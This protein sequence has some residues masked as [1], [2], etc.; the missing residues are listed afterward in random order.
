MRGDT[1]KRRL[2]VLPTTM[3]AVWIALASLIP[4]PLLQPPP[5]A[6]QACT[7]GQ[8]G[9]GDPYFPTMGNG[10]YDV[11]HYDLDLEIDVPGS[12][13]VTATVTLEALAFVDLCSFNLD[14]EGL[15]IEEVTIDDIP[16]TFS[17]NGKELTITP[18]RAIEAGEWFAATVRYHGKPV[19]ASFSDSEPK[20]E[21]AEDARRGLGGG[22]PDEVI[23]Y[24]G[25]WFTAK[26]EIFTLGQPTGS[27]FWYPVNEHPADKATYSATYT[28][29][30]PF[31]VV[32]N[33]SPIDQIDDESTTTYVWESRDSIASYLVTFHAGRLE[34]EELKGPNGLPIRLSFAPSVPEDQRAVFRKLPDMIAYAETVFGPYP[35]ES[36]GATVT[37]TKQNAA[38]ETQTLP[39]YGSKGDSRDTP[40]TA[41]QIHTVEF[42]IFHEMAHQWFGNSVS[43][44]H[45]QD[46]WLSE[47][48]ASYGEALW[49]EHTKGIPARDAWLK[50]YYAFNQLMTRLQDPSRRQEVTAQ[51]VLKG[52]QW[53]GYCADD[54]CVTS[55]MSAIGAERD[56]D[57]EAIPGEEALAALETMNAAPEGFPGPPVLTGDPGGPELFSH[58]AVYS[59]GALTLHALRLEVGDETFFAILQAWAE[60]YNNGN[61]A[62]AD[63]IAV[64]EEVSG[65]ELGT[66]FDAWLYQPALPPLAFE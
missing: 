5:A 66:L 1:S 28:V 16:A 63:F 20:A 9:I 21:S 30:K 58:G 38:L 32:A 14:F 31:V 48:F 27:R 11:Q 4:P 44:Q 54:A 36:A 37:S 7:A 45:W 64:A 60:R 33:G 42:T 40:L 18:A 50:D 57:L 52:V 39:I 62:T 13:I 51:D 56:A 6:A 25:G 34:I 53:E 43:V 55:L 26:D 17:R 19:V 22:D 2:V 29:A 61:G 65:Q 10:G 49:Y 15:E 46:I 8:I 12:E 47:G 41:Q 59:R 23:G 35:F 3:L 24:Q